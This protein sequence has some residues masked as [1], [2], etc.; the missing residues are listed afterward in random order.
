M[1]PKVDDVGALIR[2]GAYA[3][4]LP[5]QVPWRATELLRVAMQEDI[6]LQ[7]RAVRARAAS[8][9]Y[10]AAL[11]LG[12][13]KTQKEVVEVFGIRDVTLRNVNKVVL[14]ATKLDEYEEQRI[15]TFVKEQANAHDWRKP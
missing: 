14:R 6:R 10:L 13:R 9:V 5:P 4:D 2:Q 3:L 1:R 7:G 8:A 15:K 12:Y 11:V